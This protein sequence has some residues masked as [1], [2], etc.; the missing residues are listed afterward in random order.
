MQRLALRMPGIL[1]ASALALPAQAWTETGDAGDLPRSAQ[2]VTWQFPGAL[3]SIAGA[4]TASDV[5][6]Y[7]LYINDPAAFSASTVGGA[8][9]DT[10]LFLF[11]PD[12]RGVTHDDDTATPQSAISGTNVPHPGLYYLAISGYNAD[13]IASGGFIWNNNPFAIERQPDGPRRL[14]SVTAWSG[15]GGLGSYT[16]ALTGCLRPEPEMVAPDFQHLSEAA[17]QLN[18]A[19]ST[20]WW[21]STGGRFQILYEASHF[22]NAG[23]VGGGFIDRLMF[24]GE[25]GEQNLGGQQWANVTVQ[26]V[27]TP[28][29]AAAL[30]NDF[31][32]NL[33]AGTGLAT[34][35]FPTVTVGASIG[36]TPNNY[37]INLDLGAALG[38]Y[39]FNP[40]LGNL[41]IDVT[42]P[43]AATLPAASG[44][45]MPIEDTTGTTAIIRGRGVNTA[46]A[47]ATT[48]T[49]S[50]NPPVVGF[51]VD[52]TGAGVAPI[53][54]ARN[55]SYGTA[56]GGAPSSF[57]QTFVEGQAFDLVGLTLTP[58][59]AAAPNFYQVTAGAAAF[60][61]TQV[62]ATPN[63][64]GDDSVV[65]H[66]PGFTFN[67][68]GGSTA[69]IG[70][71]TNGY[72]WL[73]GTTTVGDFSPTV[74]E[75]LG[76]APRIAAYWRD[77]HAGFNTAT[78]PNSGLH[79]LTVGAAPNRVC[80]VTW[81]NV[82]AF[83]TVNGVG[84]GGHSVIDF[85]MAIFETSNVVEL[86]YGRVP[87]YATVSTGLTIAGFSRGLIGTV[88]SVDPQTRDL[89]VEVPF[90]TSLEG[91]AGNIGQ[92]IV[93]TPAAGGVQYGGRAFAGQTLTF[94]AVNVPA[95]TL[96]G[97]QLLDFVANRPGLNIPGIHPT[98]CA[99]AVSLSP[100]LHQVSLFPVGTV[101]GTAP[102]TVP[103]GV[104]GF[105]LYA[106]YAALDG[107]FGGPSLVTQLSNAVIIRV[108][109]N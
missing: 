28:V 35:N 73:N 53:V 8:T 91:A 90:V 48:G 108:G 88:A 76:G 65:S 2:V 30:T 31:A 44:G 11:F 92:R 72:V 42:M 83:N 49:L 9:F 106:Q 87:P 93:A 27:R 32:A 10:Q 79:V 101:V 67:F 71:C 7:L 4:L 22:Q 52:S 80:Y 39:S 86:R 55:E 13:P 46:T 57:Y 41:L 47:T 77:L 16:I 29:T 84:I 25:S 38:G 54:P 33:A 107:L 75:L 94:D 58:D 60:D 24:R 34:A 12:G 97:V 61:A 45:V 74:G 70:A 81:F 19:G 59:N 102:V 98:G 37:C 5:D 100:V 40:S 89:S 18:T 1:F 68:P 96:L 15:T 26:I 62:N 21:R 3:P 51:K 82:G 99:Q 85:Q 14:E 105:E 43:T 17:T 103:A 6:M 78:N 23:Y 20:N 104:E 66:T 95:G 64:V 56:C 36:S 63:S 109:K 50:A 69:A